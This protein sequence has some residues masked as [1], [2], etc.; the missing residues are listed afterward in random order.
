MAAGQ[1]LGAVADPML[2]QATDPDSAIRALKGKFVGTVECP[3]P[4]FSPIPRPSATPADRLTA[5]VL[6]VFSPPRLAQ[7]QEHRHPH[8]CLGTSIGA[9]ITAVHLGRGPLNMI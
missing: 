2:S 3:A 6:S 9:R 7:T 8:D 5:L 1:S 4:R